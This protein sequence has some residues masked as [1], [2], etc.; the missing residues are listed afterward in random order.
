[1][2]EFT[3]VPF[4]REGHI[5][6]HSHV[7]FFFLPKLIHILLPLTSTRVVVSLSSFETDIRHWYSPSSDTSIPMHPSDFRRSKSWTRSR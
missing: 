2:E 6:I 3:R 1:V 4:G 5:S 7:S